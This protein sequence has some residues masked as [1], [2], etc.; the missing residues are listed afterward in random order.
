MPGEVIIVLMVVV[1]V[2]GLAIYGLVALFARFVGGRVGSDR[3]L[4]RGKDRR[5]CV[6]CG[7]LTPGGGDRCD[8]CG[9]DLRGPLAQ[10]LADL[11][12]LERQLRRFRDNRSLKH[13][14]VGNL[15]TRVQGYRRR[16]LEPAAAPSSPVAVP[17]VRATAEKPVVAELVEEPPKLAAATARPVPPAPKPTPP[18]P[19]PPAAEPVAPATPSPRATWRPPKPKPPA[20]PPAPRKSWAEMLAGFMEQR[21][22]RWIELI[23]GLLIV[24]SSV[25]LVLSLWQKLSGYQYFQYFQF[26]IFVAATSAVFG[27]GL[28]AHHRWKLESTSRGLL[29]IA[30]LLVP[31][32]FLFMALSSKDNADAIT[33]LAGLIAL[34][35]FAWLVGLAGRVLVPGGRWLQ[36]AAVLGCSAAVPVVGWW[37]VEESAGWWLVAAG[38]LPVAFF[39]TAVGG[40]LFGLR[41]QEQVDAPGAAALFTLLG[42]G[43]FALLVALGLLV[44]QTGGVS[45]PLDFLSLPVALAALPILACGLTAGRKTAHDA[46][47]AAYQTA[48]TTIALL[49]MLAMLAALAL[50]WPRPLGIIAIG[51]LNC[52][53][54]VL[55]AFYYRLPVLHAGAIASL[56]LAY[57]TVFHWFFGDLAALSPNELNSGMLEAAISAKSGTAL[58]GLFL[59][60]GLVAELL[61]R[62]GRHRHGMIYAG[63]C[64]VVAVLGLLLV[65][66]HGFAATEELDALRAAVLYAVYGAGSLA[67][68]A[69]W[70][71]AELSYLGL[72]LLS[73]APMWALWSHSQTHDVALQVWAA[74]LAGEALLLGAIAA[75]LRHRVEHPPANTWS[76]HLKALRSGSPIELYR[77]PLL[78]VAEIVALV[79][80]TIGVLT[81]FLGRE[82]PLPVITAGCLAALCLL[83]AWTYRS[84]A[85]TWVGSM[86]VL[87]GLIHTLGFNY[88]QWI[89]QP[90]LSLLIAL[91]AHSTLAVAAGVL[92]DTWTKS[93]SDHLLP[94]P[95][96]RG[97]GPGVRGLGR[98]SKSQSDP[99][100]RE[101][102]G[103]VF[104][105]PLGESALLSSALGVPVLASEFASGTMST[106]SLALCL[107]WL[108]AVW[109]VISW[110]NRHTGLFAAHQAV[111]ALA[112]LVATAAWLEH[113]QSWVEDLPHD[114]Y[115]HP[116][117]L[118]SYGIGLGLLSL[119][120]MVLRIVLAR[121]LSRFSRSENGT[122]PFPRFSRSE[123]GTV[124][125]PPSASPAPLLQPHG[126]AVDRIIRH[127]VV[128]LQLLLVGWHLLPGV[129]HELLPRSP[130]PSQTQVAV[131][132]GAWILLAVMAAVMVLTLWY[133]W[134]ISMLSSLLLAATIPCL[135]AGQFAAPTQQAVASALRWG[136]AVCFVVCSIAVWQRKRLLKAV[137]RAR[138]NVDVGPAGYPLGARAA[139]VTLLATTAAPVLLLTVFAALLQLG[140]AA[141]GGPAAESFFDRLGPNVS[142]VVPLLLVMLGLVGYAVRERSA[143]Y[144]FSAGLVAELTVTLGYA[145]Y[146]TTT[147]DK[148]S[149]AELVTLIQLATIT[150]AAWA[151]GWL[152]VRQW[153][154]VWREQPMAD[155]PSAAKQAVPSA[156]ERMPG[157]REAFSGRRH[158]G[159]TPG[160]LMSVQLGMGAVGNVLLLGVA[161]LTMALFHPHGQAWTV[162]T[163][164]P[165]GWMAM[166]SVVG[167]YVYRRVQA[168]RRLHPQWVG[169]LGMAV[170]GLLACTV[171]G[172][173]LWPEWGYRT[174]MLG[175]AMYAWFIVLATWWAASVRTL[176]QSEGPPQ[177]M[178]RAAAV[179]VRVAGILAVL[180][181]L[182]AA[183]WHEEDR[184]WAAA[185]I[186]VASAA[187]ATMAVWRRR[188]GWAFSAAW[189]VNLAASLVVWHFQRTL[190][191]Q[192][193]WLRLA[194]ANVIASAAVALV[195]LAA[196]KRLYQLRELSLGESP[197]LATQTM[198]AVAG[199][200]LL[201]IGPVLGLVLA[202]G[203]G[204]PPGSGSTAC[205]MT[206]L[207]S[208]PGWLGLLLA[209]AAAGWYLRQVLPGNLLHVLGGL[210]LGAGVLLACHATDPGT[211][212]A[213][214]A[215][216]SWLAY[217]ALTIAWAAAALL[218]LSLGLL[219]G[220]VRL[221]A[222]DEGSGVRGQGSGDRGPATG[223]SSSIINHQS[224]IIN[225]PR[226][227]VPGRQ[228]IFPAPLVQGWVTA[229][230]GL[231]LL[232][233]VIHAK[234]DP[235]SP[236]VSGSAILSVSVMAGVLAVWLRRPAYVFI[237]GL[238]LNVIG[239]IA[240]LVWAEPAWELPSL[241]GFVQA[242]VL[243]LG[244]GSAVWSLLKLALPQGVP[245]PD[246]GGR[247]LAFGRLA[248]RSGVGLLAGVVALAVAS[249]AFSLDHVL[250]TQRLDWIALAA[251]AAAV[252]LSLWDRSSRLALPGLY[253]L[254]LA[255]VGMGLSAREVVAREFCHPAAIDLAAFVLVTAGLAVSLPRLTGV[256][257]ALRIPASGW[258]VADRHRTLVWWR[259]KALVGDAPECLIPGAALRYAPATDWLPAAQ[260]VVAAVVAGLSVWI[261]LDFAFDGI[262]HPTL[263]WLSGRIPGPLAA[264]LLLPAAILSAGRTRDRWRRGW[265]QAALGLGLVVLTELG[266]VWLVPQGEPSWVWLHRS[267]ILMVAAVVMTLLAGLGLRPLLPE[268]SDWIHS[269]R[270]VTRLFAALAL[271]MLAVVLAQEGLLFDLENGTPMEWPA[272]VVVGLALAALAAGCIGCA[273]RPDWD[274]LGLDDR[275][276]Q[277]YVYAAEAFLGLI[278]LHI[279]LTMPWLFTRGL[280][281]RFWMLIVMAI[282]LVGAGLS[283]WFHRRRVPILSQPLE[284]TALVLPLVPAIG[285]WFMQAT[286]A[287]TWFL[288][289]A[290]PATWLLMGLFYGLMAV[291]RR[292]LWLGGLA[293]L[294][295]NTGLWVLWDR[296]DVEIYEHPQLWLIPIALAALA[297]EYLNH[298]RLQKAQSTA[299]R[300][301]ALSVIY[302]SSTADMF[303][304]GLEE[305]HFLMPLILMVLAVI[306]ALAGIL[307]RVRSFLY[308]GVTFLALDVVTMVW[309]AAVQ[310]RIWWIAA[311]C[312]IALGIAV[313]ILVGVFEKRRND[314]LAAVERLK[315]WER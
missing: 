152:V 102:V 37:V 170:L 81:G 56:A 229:I 104:S 86:L 151:G 161:L 298:D 280:V 243:C 88:D 285:Y 254:A 45:G 249:H 293:I 221:A 183:F 54:L 234:A 29:A 197:L 111:L 124:P 307:L 34:G 147:G 247:R 134:R 110:R 311:V 196:R 65:T 149:V 169:L 63:G 278:A 68:T 26:S 42:T 184:L 222:Q 290:S 15:L 77:L 181:G 150:A 263:G 21:N 153:L 120:W 202:P 226:P 146:V 309:Y 11:E 108:A 236:W 158:V 287:E 218:V 168:G 188:E 97:E 207:A 217:H 191:F 47:L 141:P 306:G 137:A 55:A 119:L 211:H 273:V 176:P 33:V 160:L 248:A 114:L 165:L 106:W 105:K 166:L 18:T 49:G 279:W 242:N 185:A 6:F 155:V 66:W 32:S 259:S 256:W 135:I 314:I 130:A 206:E 52:A 96:S 73:A 239:V 305:W 51:G 266:F 98:G 253:Y 159:P 241:A 255:A 233:A 277:V 228:L 292:S 156:P 265:Q 268:T 289:Q 182:K 193:W 44:S 30:T 302:A 82:T 126:P 145:L 272:T 4:G 237:S 294:A 299:V 94:S 291:H 262:T 157:T 115:L 205:W 35:I 304:T 121:G 22:I 267:V 103:R 17:L 80:L 295:G 20:A 286:T 283:E 79:A 27:V 164:S 175:W 250:V 143:G 204:A 41:Q 61:A 288:G 180:L 232:L 71:R 28:Y 5:P 83:L 308:L 136:S 43:A 215:R 162:A 281:R 23:G 179:W 227:A 85:R 238:L 25:A 148:F 118:Q 315:D 14:V 38:C 240:W 133:R 90:R 252:V 257:Q 117:S 172:P 132:G 24:G 109:L 274:P 246:V 13:E 235:S 128:C 251:T 271:L 201:L 282:A 57:L 53:A 58:G 95:G 260:G 261:S 36:A 100:L 89:A 224:S 313:L 112:V 92:L 230:G 142:Y 174:L 209:A 216:D 3:K 297:A 213:W 9:R 139:R 122:V 131:A 310:Q 50:A 258:L 2:I 245:E 140:G 87:A 125:L 116:Q 129:G 8:W 7:S 60:L 270:K 300:Y 219:G 69:R 199:N 154:D 59:A 163:G 303:M 244:I 192:Q 212:F 127:A 10:E 203:D 113:P 31:L 186:A 264:A 70:R 296:L 67:L 171:Q 214:F 225:S 275:Q 1:A 194:E 301:L 231:V 16:L 190:D 312:G 123:N 62:R 101:T 167:A 198:L 64:G 269:G 200:V 12:A 99:R 46:S 276:R 76:D 144:A 93:R 178:I 208:V 177:A 19:E 220:G 195:W 84:Q 48:G 107:F 72:S 40:Y 223:A 284:R 39:A 138:A 173:R 189:G 91:L 78:H 75:V 74:V 210:G 187:G